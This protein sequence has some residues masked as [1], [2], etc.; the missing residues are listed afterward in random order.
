MGPISFSQYSHRGKRKRYIS[1]DLYVDT[2]QKAVDTEDALKVD[3]FKAKHKFVRC[4]CYGNMSWE[5]QLVGHL[6]V[7]VSYPVLSEMGKRAILSLLKAVEEHMAA[8]LCFERFKWPDVLLTRDGQVLFNHVKTIQSSPNARKNTVED[9]VSVVEY[10]TKPGKIPTDLVHLLRL[11]DVQAKP[12]LYS[13]HSSLVPMSN[14]GWA[15]LRDILLKLPYH[16]NWRAQV[17]QNLVLQETYQ[18]VPGRYDSRPGN[19]TA[20]QEQLESA[21][22]F[23][24]FL[25]N[26]TSHRA[27]RTLIT[28]P[29]HFELI[30]F[31]L[32]PLLLPCLQ[33]AI[34]DVLQDG[35]DF[36][37]GV[38]RPLMLS[39]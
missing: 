13:I 25:R 1:Y 32:F 2:R 27:Q 3:T 8:G 29:S 31:V 34:Y 6:I 10:F 15:R 17:Q 24:D 38:F 14:R 12:E 28:L 5:Y 23:L 18:F 26:G 39:S 21:S 36:L 4:A 19:K 30:V 9:T 22:L 20:V 16:S 33:E 7:R 37:Q 35:L 11:M